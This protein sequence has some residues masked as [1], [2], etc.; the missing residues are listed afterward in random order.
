MSTTTKTLADDVLFQNYGKRNISIVRGDGAFLYDDEG[1]EYL[2]FTAGIAVC[3]LGHAHPGV[4]AV[5]SEQA[6]TLIHTSNL[7]L[8]QGQ[9][10]LARKLT[11]LV[12]KSVPYRT[13]F[14]NSGTEANEGALK[15]ARRYQ[16][17]QGHG[18]KT[19]ILSLPHGF[20][21]RTF[22]S[23]S[24]TPKAAYHEGF[25]PLVPGFE[26]PAALDDVIDHVDDT[27]AACIVEVIQG[28][29]GVR[30]LAAD[31]VR[32]L[33]A[34][35][36]E[37]GALL[38]V[39]EVQT[40]VGR[41]GTFFGFEAYGIEPD[42]VTLA[43]GLGNGVPTGA[44]LAKSSVAEA[45][46]PGAHGTTFGGNPLAMAVANYVVDC[47]SQPD[48]LKHVQTVGQALQS[49]LTAHFDHVDGRGLM[50]GFD[51]PDA[52]VWA[53]KAA[54]AGLLV[55]KCSNQRIRIL[56]PLIIDEHHVERFADILTSVGT[57]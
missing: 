43:K 4:A 31:F 25:T 49:V 30:P 15:L 29:A 56:P 38:I 23:L 9:V 21:G 19:K 8:V 16:Y 35:L 44:I 45:F 18:D 46:T 47:V 6:R 11:Q 28:E 57:V 24:V 10:D 32:A 34:K 53:A 22:G 42:I 37:K 27:V 52:N 20:H 14:V 39:D 55:T 17:L 26:T 3:N 50:W 7:F 54:D 12:S 1:K 41:T 5:I 40:G 2:D 51:V 13:M 48:F 33:A 36:K